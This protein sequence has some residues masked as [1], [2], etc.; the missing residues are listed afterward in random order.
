MHVEDQ[1]RP[2]LL[3]VPVRPSV[4]SCVVCRPAGGQVVNLMNQRLQTG[5]SEAEVLQVF[6]D[7]CEALA[8]LHQCKTPIV[9]RDLK[10]RTLLYN[11]KPPR[12]LKCRGRFIVLNRGS[13]TPHAGGEHPAPRPGALRALWLRERHQPLPEPSDR[14]CATGGRGDQEVSGGLQA[15]ESITSLMNTS[16]QHKV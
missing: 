5:F 14:G 3:N 2:H 12:Y 15:R 7:T 16:S 6:C 13:F 4:W 9:H 8:R 11:P 1:E 10:V